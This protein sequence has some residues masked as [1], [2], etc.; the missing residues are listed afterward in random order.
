MTFPIPDAA[1]EHHLALLGKTG[2]GKSYAAQGVVEQLIEK[3]QR[4]CVID[5]TDRYWGLRLLADGKNPSGYEPVIFGGQHADLPLAATHGAALAEIAG[6]TTTPIIV[7]T[8]LMTVGE[9]SR[10]FTAFAETLLRV[11]EGP[12]H[13]VIDEAHLFA[14]Q[15]GAKIGGEA[16]ALLHATNNLVSL[17]RG[18]GLRIMLLS[19]RPAKLH[20]DSLTQVE[21]LVAFRL[22]APQDRN[23]IRAW[24]QE[25]ADEATGAEMMASLPSLP[26]GT[27]WLWAPE[28]DALK[29][30]A[31]PANDTFDSGKPLA[32]RKGPALKP[33]DLSA[34]RGKLEIVAKEAA[35]NDPKR[36]KA[37]VAQLERELKGHGD[38]IDAA[39]LKSAED[40]AFAAGVE[41]GKRATAAAYAEREHGMREAMKAAMGYLAPHLDAP[42]GET[43]VIQ[44]RYPPLRTIDAAP[45]LAP[46][47]RIAARQTAGSQPRHGN[48][49][50]APLAS[51]QRKLLTVLAQYPEGRSKRQLAILA[52]YAHN[53]GAFN[54]YLGTLRS[55]GWMEGQGDGPLRITG[56][57]YDALGEFE[58]LPTGR[59]L[60]EYWLAQLDKAP[61]LVLEACAERYPDALSK[62]EVAAAA[63]YEASGGGFNNAL[64]KLRTLGL[65]EG[66]GEVRAS[67]E[68]FS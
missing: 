15:A 42:S 13:L 63:G 25:W 24:V 45:R 60:L 67:D 14:P 48:G 11:N 1:L 55:A 51:G 28:L 52:G 23:A 66:R 43:P 8:R 32:G 62:D 2:S 58:P 12:L 54:N 16:P 61:R 50:S 49:A 30:I 5:P 31:F 3:R 26:T 37:R 36:L 9:R 20:K 29:K 53:G 35:E 46:S 22:I 18:I 33:I 41:E 19:Q 27:A 39:V 64:S 56:A 4:V 59:A 17:G 34:V 38:Q 47:P 40:R 6:T 44:I 10:F 7:S 21:T 68:L 65:I 57:G